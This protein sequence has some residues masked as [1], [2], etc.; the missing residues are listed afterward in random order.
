M[1]TK[2]TNNRCSGNILSKE[3]AGQ[4]ALRLSRGEDVAPLLSSFFANNA[5]AYIAFLAITNRLIIQKG[6]FARTPGV[7]GNVYCT[8]VGDSLYI[9]DTGLAAVGRVSLARA[10]ATERH[11]KDF[12]SFELIK[13]S[14]Q[15]VT[16]DEDY[17]YLDG[18]RYK[19]SWNYKCSGTTG[20]SG[21]DV[22]SFSLN[23]KVYNLKVYQLIAALEFGYRVIDTFGYYGK[24][25]FVIHHIDPQSNADDRGNSYTTGL[26]INRIDNLKLV[27]P[28]EHRLIHKRINEEKARKRVE[29][30][31]KQ[32]EINCSRFV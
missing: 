32:A 27:T 31:R 7:N 2:L 29:A 3:T 17:I 10:K 21:T 6:S 20:S 23:N 8:R 26:P 24:T 18:K 15:C 13:A 12:T 22:V 14:F 4:L 9:V 16:T 1:N 5:R 11:L 28:E 30:Y 25:P 19:V